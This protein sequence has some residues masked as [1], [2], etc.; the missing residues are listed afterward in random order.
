MTRSTVPTPEPPPRMR[1]RRGAA[2]PLCLGLAFAASCGDPGSGDA[3]GS[4]TSSTTGE[5]STSTS[6]GS[7]GESTGGDPL[8][9]LPARGIALTHVDANQGVAVPITDADGEWIA[10]RTTS[11]IRH[12]PLMIRAFIDVVDDWQ[13]REIEGRLHLRNAGGEESDLVTVQTVSAD[14]SSMSAVNSFVWQLPAE[15][16]EPGLEFQVALF[17][18]DDAMGDTPDPDP[19]PVHPLGGPELVGVEDWPAELRLTL[20][21]VHSTFDGCALTADLNDEVVE[22]IRASV[23]TINPVQNVPITVAD[24]PIEIAEALTSGKQVTDALV[25]RRFADGAA[26]NEYYVG[27]YV[28]CGLTLSGCMAGGIP[29]EPTEESAYLRVIAQRYQPPLT[30]ASLATCL[31][32]AQGR[33]RVLCSGDEQGVDPNYPYEGGVIGVWGWNIEKNLIQPP[34][35]RYDYLSS[36]SPRWVSDYTWRGIMPVVK[37]LTSWDYAP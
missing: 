19:A 34:E 5:G 13:E 33:R 15:A 27:L 25:D 32:L 1:R 26:P 23:Y 28:G 14:S 10:A 18:V 21:P 17:E 37:E 36:C 2:L 31:G 6:A 8:A 30:G 29:S 9:P 16:V 22:E 7:T 24:S 4:A 11:L 35:T 12:R 3:T 20:V